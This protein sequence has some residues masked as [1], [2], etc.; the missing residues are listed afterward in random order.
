VTSDEFDHHSSDV[1]DDDEFDPDQ[2]LFAQ[3]PGASLCSVA[4]CP[5]CGLVVM[6][7]LAKAVT[8]CAQHT[9]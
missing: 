8:G 5:D 4:T 2:P 9:P 7:P 1:Y 3:E 6:V